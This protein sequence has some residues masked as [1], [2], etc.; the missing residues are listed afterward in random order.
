MDKLNYDNYSNTKIA[1]RFEL[2]HAGIPHLHKADITAIRNRTTGSKKTA[3]EKAKL[4]VV[5]E[6][7]VVFYEDNK[8]FHEAN[9][10]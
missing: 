4:S 7:C 10:S 5:E 3:F 9:R 2:D 1:L 6:S 8:K